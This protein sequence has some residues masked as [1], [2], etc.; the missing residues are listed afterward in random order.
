MWDI[1]MQITSNFVKGLFACQNN[2]QRFNGIQN[3]MKK[4]KNEIVAPAATDW[5]EYSLNSS[6]LSFVVNKLCFVITLEKLLIRVI[7]YFYFFFKI[8]VLFL[9]QRKFQDTVGT[10]EVLQEFKMFAD[11]DTDGL[12]IKKGISITPDLQ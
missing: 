10:A 12:F 11:L 2:S 7:V 5:A 8:D 4:E 9:G 1:F 6:W 3:F